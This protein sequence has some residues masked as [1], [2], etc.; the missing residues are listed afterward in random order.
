M[1]P[2]RSRR[3]RARSRTRRRR[4]IRRVLLATGA[5][6]VALVLALL[7]LVEHFLGGI[8]RAPLLPPYDGPPGRGQNILL[9][10]SDS[11]AGALRLDAR[12]DVIQLVHI[13]ADGRS[14]AVVHVP[15]D[16]YV[17]IPGHGRNKINAAYAFGGAPLVVRTLERLLG[18]GIDHVAQTGFGGF[19]DITDTVHGVDMRVRT[20]TAQD[21][22][23]GVDH[24]GW[25]HFDGHEALG[26]VRV[27]HGLRL[28]DIDRGRRE[29]QWLAAMFGKVH[30]VDTLLDPVRL[31][32][33][34][35]DVSPHLV[36]DETFTNAD[37][38]ALA[39]QTRHLSARRISWLTAPW[40]GFGSVPGVGD[41]VTPDRAGL[42]R[43]G[44]D[45]RTD[46]MQA[47]AAMAD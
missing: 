16:L 41:T 40:S 11:R 14:A 45:L 13:S 24:P 29:Q 21:H 35:R 39:V 10:G 22:L 18:I 6:L 7:W 33:L 26:Y 20:V 17:S 27:R 19:A 4:R 32:A 47:L 43:L 15:R 2:G 38:R 1:Q 44:T 23:I 42:R 8:Q 46:D 25:H 28:G 9:L 30:R 37:I 12:S 3:G 36:L 34:A 5:V 31:V